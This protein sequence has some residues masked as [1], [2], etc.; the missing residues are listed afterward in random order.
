MARAA[1]APRPG[2]S[3]RTLEIKKM[4]IYDRHILVRLPNWVGDVVM[5]TPTL[6]CLRLNFPKARIDVT[7]LPYVRDVIK[8]APWIDE[9][10][11]IP[12][13]RDGATVGAMREYV[14]RLRR[15]QYDLALVLPNSVSSAVLAYLSGAKQRIGYDRQ[16]RGFL[17][18][19]PVPPPRV[20]GKF[21]PQPMVDYY[22]KLCEATGAVVGS[23]TTEMFVDAESERRVEELFSTYRIGQKGG[24]VALAPG[25][26][27]GSSKLWDPKKFGRLADLLAERK[28]CDVLIVGGPNER[29]IAREIVAASRI[30]PVNLVE[31]NLNLNLLKSIVKRCDLFVTVDSGPRH[32]AV[33]FDKP[34]VVLVG[35]IDPAYTNC[36]LQK[37][38]IVK[39]ENVDCAPCQKKRCPTDHRC[40]TEISSEMV[41]DAASRLLESYPRTATT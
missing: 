12:R 40:M 17:L 8:G 6:R 22:L 4:A 30:K 23:T 11:E 26:A 14:N 27:F 13:R 25:A 10:I 19:D 39:A 5:A 35:A 41:F 15:N 29:P 20:K 2:I 36:N 16:G 1:I 9:I 18:T 32:F 33:A 3:E 37:T 28:N 34:V 31:E 24:I 7:L 38:L 21:V